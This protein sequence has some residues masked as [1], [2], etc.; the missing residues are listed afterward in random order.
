MALSGQQTGGVEE[1]V[2]IQEYIEPVLTMRLAVKQRDLVVD[3]LEQHSRVQFEEEYTAGLSVAARLLFGSWEDLGGGSSRV[4]DPLVS[5]TAPSYDFGIDSEKRI[6]T[7]ESLEDAVLTIL[8]QNS[9]RSTELLATG[10]EE[11]IYQLAAQLLLDSAESDITAIAERDVVGQADGHRP[12]AVPLSATDSSPPPSEVTAVRR[13]V[14]LRLSELRH[15]HRV[16][17]G[18]AEQHFGAEFEGDERTTKGMLRKWQNRE[19]HKQAFHLNYMNVIPWMATSWNFAI[20]FEG[21]SPEETPSLFWNAMTHDAWRSQ[22]A[23]EASLE[24]EIRWM[25]SLQSGGVTLDQFKSH[26]KKR[27]AQE[28]GQHVRAVMHEVPRG[29]LQACVGTLFTLVSN[30]LRNPG[31]KRFRMIPIMNNIIRDRVYRFPAAVSLLKNCAGF[32]DDPAGKPSLVLEKVDLLP[33]L[34][35]WSL[36]K[37]M[38]TLGV[39]SSS[40]GDQESATIENSD[41]GPLYFQIVVLQAIKMCRSI[42]SCRPTDRIFW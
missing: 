15:R 34:A 37:K 14:F 7:E 8:E 38:F 27:P 11:R 20:T 40:Q 31:D 23:T 24:T 30:I 21:D 22:H 42:I 1:Y 29:H 16:L 4:S 12:V 10:R 28:L 19:Q 18:W 9:G 17:A 36:L 2:G 41:V 39:A 35:L 13:Q 32:V 5:D 33:L 26:A 3:F 6:K 25:D